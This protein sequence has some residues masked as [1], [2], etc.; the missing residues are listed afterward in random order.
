MIDVIAM[1][2]VVLNATLM[3]MVVYEHGNDGCDDASLEGSAEC[4]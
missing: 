4:T 2:A 3:A 1:S